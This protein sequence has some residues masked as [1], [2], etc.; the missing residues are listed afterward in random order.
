MAQL[1]EQQLAL[2]WPTVRAHYLDAFRDCPAPG[3][4]SV[5]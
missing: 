5:D 4:P 1:G 3:D 2:P